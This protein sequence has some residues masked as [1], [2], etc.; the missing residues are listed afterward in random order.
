MICEAMIPQW[1][2]I[3]QTQVG[4]SS[5]PAFAFR[6]PPQTDLRNVLM[7]VSTYCLP[8]ILP[9]SQGHVPVSHIGPS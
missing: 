5:L 7:S 2:A 4:Y 8:V 1:L 9:A 6:I 3:C